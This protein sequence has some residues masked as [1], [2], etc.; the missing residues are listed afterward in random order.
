MILKRWLFFGRFLKLVEVELIIWTNGIALYITIFVVV[1]GLMFEKNH[2]ILLICTKIGVFFWPISI[3]FMWFFIMHLHAVLLILKR[4]NFIS[5]YIINKSGNNMHLMYASNW[6]TR[7]FV[8]TLWKFPSMELDVIFLFGW[9]V[10]IE[11]LSQKLIKMI[12]SDIVTYMTSAKL[13][14]Y[15]N[16]YNR[17]KMS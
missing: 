8:H 12:R 3:S 5:I 13:N 15:I 14:V 4:Y 10:F 1:V 17:I 2:R 16:I 11:F 7:L 6:I 9:H